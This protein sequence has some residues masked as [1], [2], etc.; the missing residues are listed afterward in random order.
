MCAGGRSEFGTTATFARHSN[1]VGLAA[2]ARAQGYGILPRPALIRDRLGNVDFRM[3]FR[4]S[5]DGRAHPL[6]RHARICRMT[7]L[8]HE[9]T[10]AACQR[11]V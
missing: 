5:A 6:R 10:F 8:G 9:P 11:S 1:Y 3:L 7:G 2:K 4:R